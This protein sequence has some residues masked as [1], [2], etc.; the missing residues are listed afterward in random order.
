MS[1]LIHP[2]SKNRRVNTFHGF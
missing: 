2:K 1:S